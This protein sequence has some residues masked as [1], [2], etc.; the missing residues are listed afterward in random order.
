MAC[1]P[2]M[3]ELRRGTLA[4]YD[5]GVGI[6]CLTGQAVSLLQPL[7]EFAD[8]VQSLLECCFLVLQ[9]LRL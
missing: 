2:V 1:H 8:E 4:I 7:L 3:P 6:D 5:G 9:I